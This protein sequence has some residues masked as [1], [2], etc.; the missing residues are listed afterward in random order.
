MG[1]AQSYEDLITQATDRVALA[2]KGLRQAPRGLKP[3]RQ[4]DLDD[5]RRDLRTLMRHPTAS[6]KALQQPQKPKGPVCHCGAE[7]WTTRYG[8]VCSAGTHD[9]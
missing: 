2:L 4:R 7:L 8:P 3:Y 1:K 6:L 9:D 5:A